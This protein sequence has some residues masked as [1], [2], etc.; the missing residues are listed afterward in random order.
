MPHQLATFRDG[1]LT[2]SYEVHG[3]GERVLVYMHGVL[4]DSRVNRRL[5]VDLAAAGHRVVLLDLPGHGRSD[6][7]RQVAA[8]RMDAYARHVLHLLDELGVEQVAVGGMSLGADVTLQLGLLAPA[9]LRAMVLEMPVLELATPVAA[10]TFTPLVLATHYAAPLLRT[11]ARLARQVPRDRFGV[12]SQLVGPWRLDP[13]E[14]SAILH[15]LAVGPVAPTA[16]ERARMDV[17]AL[18]IGHRSDRLHPFG[19]AARL[20]AQLPQARLVEARSLLELRVWPARLT[21]EISS[22]LDEAWATGRIQRSA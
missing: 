3:R 14:L 9:R 15:G 18:V 16:D 2:L 8:H 22:F 1:D 19:D 12:L 21:A 4:M 6:K 11:V 7:P 5:A 20:A 10:L 13:E 17:P